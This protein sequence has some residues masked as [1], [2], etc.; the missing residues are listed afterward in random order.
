MNET[1]LRRAMRDSAAAVVT[2]TSM[3]AET[4]RRARR[5]RARMLTA[6]LM[7]VA[8]LATGIAA[9][10]RL[11]PTP[12]RPPIAA[13][14]CRDIRPVATIG[15]D[16]SEITL[17]AATKDAVF[18]AG[19]SPEYYTATVN[20]RPR[21]GRVDA[22]GSIRWIEFDHPE[23]GFQTRIAGHPAAVSA[24]EAWFVVDGGG[25]FVGE[26]ALWHVEGDA[27]RRPAVLTPVRTLYAEQ[28]AAR[29]GRVWAA[30]GTRTGMF[31]GRWDGE[32][33]TRLPGQI[34]ELQGFKTLTVDR[35]GTPYLHVT[36]TH[37]ARMP[38]PATPGG[39]VPGIL[40]VKDALFRHDGRGWVEIGLPDGKVSAVEGG[41][42]GE[43]W[44][45]SYSP[46]SQI[47]RYADERWTKVAQAGDEGALSVRLSS[48]D[49]GRLFIAE[50]FEGD[51]GESRL[52]VLA[53]GELS[54]VTLPREVESTQITGLAA[55]DDGALWFVAGSTMYRAMCTQS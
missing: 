35:G 41:R 15:R 48:D 28:V 47:W 39:A 20:A 29:D 37:E 24:R 27:V 55:T 7:S 23:D 52:W 33:W 49:D 14:S 2:D 53:G 25:R 4:K 19:V 9:A 6:S 54:R 13:P 30:G 44:A 26:S 51:L 40:S 22:D 12:D 17:S 21:A 46:G 42:A 8:L 50:Y 45:A 18:F 11:G 31:A 5:G 38:K 34:P 36:V 43:L 32:R 16:T 3:P 10:L 1:E